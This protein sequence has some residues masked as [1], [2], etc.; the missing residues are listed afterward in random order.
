MTFIQTVT[1]FVKKYMLINI[2]NE[3]LVRY[4]FRNSSYYDV[5]I[6]ISYGLTSTLSTIKTVHLLKVTYT[7]IMHFI[8]LEFSTNRKLVIN[9]SKAGSTSLLTPTLVR[10]R[11]NNTTVYTRI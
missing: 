11:V 3:L 2:L 6:E 5:Y 4:F 9:F 1:V 10:V 8:T 7:F